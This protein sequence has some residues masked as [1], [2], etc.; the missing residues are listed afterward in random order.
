MFINSELENNENPEGNIVKMMLID[1]CG[2][3]GK[4][5]LFVF[6]RKGENLEKIFNI[7]GNEL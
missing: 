6:N 3:N 2:I 5:L 7:N 1:E 4:S